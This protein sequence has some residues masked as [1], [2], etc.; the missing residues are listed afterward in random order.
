MA[1]LPSLAQGLLNLIVT[2]KDTIVIIV[3]LSTDRHP[4]LNT[5]AVT[6]IIIYTIHSA[7]Q[8]HIRH[9]NHQLKLREPPPTAPPPP[10]DAPEE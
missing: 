4:A 5:I 9:L 1:E 2:A 6:T 3:S 8:A 10:E 7:T